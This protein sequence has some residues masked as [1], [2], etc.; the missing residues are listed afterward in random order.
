MTNLDVARNGN[1]ILLLGGNGK[2]G[3]RVSDRLAARNI[4]VRIGSRSA[5]PAFDWLNRTTWEGALEDVAAVYI[6]YYPDLAVP[7]AADTI[8]A[9][10][11]LAVQNGVRRLVLLSGR[12]EEEAQN[13]ERQLQASGADWTILRCAWFNQ[14]FSENYLLDDILAGEM[15]LPVGGVREPFVDADD[16]ADAAVA[17][18][19][20]DGHVAQLYELTGPRLLTFAD[21]A[22]EIGSARGKEVRFTEISAE[23]YAAGLRKA[24]MPEDLV[25]LLMELFTKVLDGRNEY[26]ADGV[27]RAL[28]RA[29]RDFS[30]YA[31]KAATTGIWGG[32]K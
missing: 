9:F 12:G 26:V 14:N 6:T 3:R 4:P 29:P 11:S 27:Q 32:A 18:L 15:V 20:E 22:R 21:A 16:I 7:G 1:T 30:A 8:G 5:N 24:E 25:W 23:D 28:G 10:A 2:T 17:A 13:A 31:R 19:T